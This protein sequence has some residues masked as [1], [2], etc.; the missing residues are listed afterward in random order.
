[1]RTRLFA[2]I[3]VSAALG[4]AAC[5]GGGGGASSSTSTAPPTA[6]DSTATVPVTAT[7]ALVARSAGVDVPV[8]ADPAAAEPTSVVPAFTDFGFTTVFLVVDESDDRLEVLLPTRPNG[9]SGWIARDAV[10]LREVDAE[11]HVDLTART[12]Q[13]VEA[14]AVIVETPIA[15][16]A[17]DAPTPTGRFYVTDLL[18][19]GEPDGPYGPYAVGLSGH[20]DVLTDFGGGDGQVGIHGTN[21]P[22]SIG[23][24]VS[25]GCIRVP[26]EIAA[27]LATSLPLG[28][29]VTV[30]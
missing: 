17:P 30:V 6:S 7:G 2:T 24:A 19:T 15:I 9:S 18:D 26:N 27:M 29:P 22:S 3:A 21:D 5:G 13:L 14:G 20:S 1:M 10:E 23:Q 8:F 25:H 16:G 28:T 11:I 4:L 12:L